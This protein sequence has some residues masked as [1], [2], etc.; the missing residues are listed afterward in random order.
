MSMK[1]RTVVQLYPGLTLRNPQKERGFSVVRFLTVAVN[2]WNF[3]LQVYL[4]VL[5]GHITDR[6]IDRA[7]A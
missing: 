1:E 4:E 7:Y 2:F 5:L 6:Y 3:R